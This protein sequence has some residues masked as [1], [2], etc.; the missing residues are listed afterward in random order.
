MAQLPEA[1]TTR[2]LLLRRFESGDLD[3]LAQILADPEVNRYLY[4]VP[5]N[6]GEARAALD[7]RLEIPEKTS[8][9]NIIHVAVELRESKRVVGDFM[10]RWQAN[11][12]RQGEIGGSLHPD[13]HRR[14]FATEIYEALLALAFGHYQLHRVI[15]RCDARNVASVRSLARAGLHEEAHLVENEYVK[16]EWTDEIIMALLA[17][18]W[19]AARAETA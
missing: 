11:E 8:L 4:S 10:L 5:R 7:R 13:F 9:E 2:R 17:S 18:E 19:R 12:H 6:R 15:G 14:G 3:D 16:G 1:V